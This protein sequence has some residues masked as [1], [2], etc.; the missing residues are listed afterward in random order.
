MSCVMALRSVGGVEKAVV[1]HDRQQGR[2][3]GPSVD[4]L[5]VTGLDQENR[6]CLDAESYIAPDRFEPGGGRWDFQKSA[7]YRLYGDEKR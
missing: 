6:L 2:G 4:E 5:E 7:T 1:H 3:S